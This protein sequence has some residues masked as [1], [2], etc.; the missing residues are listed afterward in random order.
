MEPTNNDLTLLEMKTSPKTAGQILWEKKGIVFILTFTTLSVV[1]IS[2]LLIKPVYQTNS[3]IMLKEESL[4]P[5]KPPLRTKK[6]KNS[7]KTKQK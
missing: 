3:K 6:M 4:N 5:Q 7:Y 2:T 1:F